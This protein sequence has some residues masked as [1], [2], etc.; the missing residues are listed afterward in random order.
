MLPYSPPRFPKNQET[1]YWQ[2]NHKISVHIGGKKIRR[3]GGNKVSWQK[4]VYSRS[5]YK[6]VSLLCL[7][8]YMRVHVW[9][10]ACVFACVVV[11]MDVHVCV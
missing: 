5:K 10:Q 8:A 9:E 2:K 11:C 1:K 6:G 4:Y 3:K 7:R